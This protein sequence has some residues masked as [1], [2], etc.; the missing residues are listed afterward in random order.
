MSECKKQRVTGCPGELHEDRENA[1][2]WRDLKNELSS[3]F[4]TLSHFRSFHSSHFHMHM[5]EPKVRNIKEKLT[6]FQPGVRYS[7]VKTKPC[8]FSIVRFG[9]LEEKA[10]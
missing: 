9:S 5:I 3:V 4:S 7:L 1:Q 2:S 6:V 10:G 8:L